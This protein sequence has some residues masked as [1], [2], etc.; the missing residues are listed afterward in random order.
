MTAPNVRRRSK[1]RAR[2]GVS[3]ARPRRGQAASP[4][5]TD[6]RHHRHGPGQG[7]ASVLRLPSTAMRRPTAW[8]RPAPRAV[9]TRQ[10]VPDAQ[11]ADGMRICPPE[12]RRADVKAAPK[13]RDLPPPAAFPSPHA[14]ALDQTILG[15][16]LQSSSFYRPFYVDGLWQPIGWLEVSDRL[17]GFDHQARD[18][19]LGILAA[20]GMRRVGSRF[21]RNAGG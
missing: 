4:R 14:G 13:S 5:R 6:Q 21:I 1:G 17:A 18:A 11:R 8:P 12:N 7:R 20:C 3:C 19:A 9:R 16:I 2:S 15:T 10:P